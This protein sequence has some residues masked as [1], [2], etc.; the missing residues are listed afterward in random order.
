MQ[1]LAIRG[2][3]DGLTGG[4]GAI[5]GASLTLDP[6]IIVITGLV[7]AFTH[8]IN[9]FFAY[10]REFEIELLDSTKRLEELSAINVDYIRSSPLYLKRKKEVQKK[11]FVA[12]FSSLIGSLILLLPFILLPLFHAMII[13]MVTAV[14][15]VALLGL[16]LGKF[17]KEDQWRLAVEFS[18]TFIIS[19]FVALLVAGVWEVR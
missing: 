18:I 16:L 7:S 3:I 13:S 14:I 4:I 10:R 6:R 1:K 9:H 17:T 12:G 2:T 19:L 15:V 8:S 11:A 5:I